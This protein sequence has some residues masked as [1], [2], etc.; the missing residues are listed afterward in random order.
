MIF[1]PQT[2]M[3]L[4]IAATAFLFRGTTKL[5][6]AGVVCYTLSYEFSTAWMHAESKVL[7]WEIG[8]VLILSMYS[9]FTR[10]WWPPLLG[11]GVLLVQW[12]GIDRHPLE[13]VV[14]A[15]IA[16]SVGVVYLRIPKDDLAEKLVWGI[17]LVAETWA[18][19]EKA[20]CPYVPQPFE[21]E[22]QCARAFGWVEPFMAT[23]L[24]TLF[25]VWIGLRWKYRKT[26]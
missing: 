23:F 14:T 16:I 11:A 2:W 19:V 21:G 15:L 24:T 18:M 6:L 8:L 5:A 3:L 22:S 9:L 25:L 13:G 26:G 1:L 12:L 7:V 10:L 4:S 20:V 17:V